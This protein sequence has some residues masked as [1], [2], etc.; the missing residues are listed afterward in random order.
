MSYILE[1]LK[2]SQQQRELGQVPRLEESWLEQLPQAAQP[3]PWMIGSLVLAILALAVALYGVLREDEEVIDSTPAAVGIEQAGTPSF[4]TADTEDTQPEPDILLVPAPDPHGQPL[5]RGA[6]EIRKAVLGDTSPLPSEPTTASQPV[7]P[8][9]PQDSVA[10]ET[11]IADI[12]AF[13]R[14]VKGHG[15]A[16]AEARQPKPPRTPESRSVAVTEP[17][18]PAP[19]EVSDPPAD[20]PAYQISVH[21]YNAE[22]SDR[23]VYI[24]G[25]K[26][27]EQETTSQGLKIEEITQAGV[28]L[29]FEGI[30]FFAR[31]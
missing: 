5:P 1:A 15:G 13:K 4:T 24:N 14:E 11:L 27:Q 2:K 20:L 30:S 29:S 3:H 22:Q 21:V 31:R 28:I 26:M 18:P 12:E 23:F 9:A 16:A 10:P 7:P 25:E 6:E 8:P 17:P 19:V